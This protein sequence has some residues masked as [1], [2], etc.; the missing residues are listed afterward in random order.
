M[1]FFCSHKPKIM[2]HNFKCYLL[3][4]ILLVF[5]NIHAQGPY[6]IPVVFHILHENGPE[7]IADSQVYD[8]MRILNNDFNKRNADTAD[9]IPP[10]QNLIA[11]VGIQFQLASLDPNGNPTNGIDR[12]QSTYTDSGGFMCMINQWN[13]HNY[14]NVWTVRGFPL[15]NG[16]GSGGPV[17]PA[18]AD[19]FPNEDGIVMLNSYTG[20]I[21]TGSP[22]T[23]R[24]LTH[25]VG[26]YLNLQHTWGGIGVP[27]PGVACGDDSVQD[28]PI[29]KG[30][31]YCP[32][33]SEA[34]VCDTTIVENY[35][36]YM[37]YSF[38]SCMFTPG[39]KARML[40][41]LNSPIAHRD[42]LFMLS[43]LIHTGVTTAIT[44]NSLPSVS[45]YPNPFNSSVEISGLT[46]RKYMIS[47]DDILGREVVHEKIVQVPAGSLVSLDLSAITTSGVYLMKIFDGQLTSTFKLVKQ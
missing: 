37:E 28:T 8:A 10:F 25:N 45:I 9:V 21:G 43:N 17:L 22:Y 26:H 30:W 40:N 4:P 44:V 35:Q 34:A 14:L 3:L 12:I 46:D 13:P 33:E 15:A 18:T 24:S 31:E 19:S 42:S 11:D 32:Y 39:Q 38:C 36:N 1:W 20:S 7:N 27:P 23:S 29:T 47:L 6:I 2:R 41:A 5:G 16:N